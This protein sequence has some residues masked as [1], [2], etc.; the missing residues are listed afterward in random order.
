MANQTPNTFRVML[1]KGQIACLTDT[2]KVILMKSGFVF[3][4]DTHHCYADVIASEVANG[5]GYTTGGATLANVAIAANDTLDRSELTWD[6]V[7]WDAVGGAL[8]TSGAIIY[9][10]TTATGSGHD[11]TDAIVSYKDAGGDIT[12]P[13]GNPLILQ[14]IMEATS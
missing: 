8:V 4:K 6:D 10:D 3:N 12:A 5:L 2:F 7:Q 13:D 11:Y 1:W 14:D 9:D